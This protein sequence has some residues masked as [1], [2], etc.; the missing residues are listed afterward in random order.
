PEGEGEPGSGGT[1]VPVMTVDKAVFETVAVDVTQGV[2]APL[3][4][5][6]IE[7]FLGDEIVPATG[8]PQDA[9]VLVDPLHLGLPFEPP[10]PDVD[11]I[12]ELGEFPGEFDHED[13]LSPG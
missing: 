8:N 11:A 6:L 10:R 12:S 9:H 1:G 4:E 7:N 2:L 3:R 13:N 5:P